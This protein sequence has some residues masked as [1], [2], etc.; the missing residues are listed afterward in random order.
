MKMKWGW[1]MQCISTNSEGC[2]HSASD[3]RSDPRLSSPSS[4]SWSGKRGWSL[5]NFQPL[6]PLLFHALFST[7]LLL[8]QP[9]IKTLFSK[10]RRKEGGR[11][12]VFQLEWST[13]FFGAHARYIFS[14]SPFLT[15]WLNRVIH[16]FDDRSLI[17]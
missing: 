7:S 6:F 12:L 9:P 2:Y 13:L 1:C 11:K 14:F 17:D 16:F 10:R 3:A 8:S 15:L 4:H 5:F